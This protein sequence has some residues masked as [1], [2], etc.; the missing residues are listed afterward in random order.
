M[1]FFEVV[2][3]LVLR[4]LLL[5]LFSYVLLTVFKNALVFKSI[6][7]QFFLYIQN[8]VRNPQGGAWASQGG[9]W[10]SPGGIWA[11]PGGVGRPQGASGRP[12]GVS[13]VPRG[14]DQRHKK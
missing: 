12:R 14:K 6:S 1:R 5:L 8:Y 11:S 9:V 2:N 7:N 3:Y 4:L 10:A 13:D